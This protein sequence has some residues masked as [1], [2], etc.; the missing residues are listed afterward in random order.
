[1]ICC[2]ITEYTMSIICACHL[3]KI[4]ALCVKYTNNTRV[5][6]SI[7]V[8]AI[9][10]HHFNTCIQSLCAC[11]I[12]PTSIKCHHFNDA[13]FLFLAAKSL[14]NGLQLSQNT[15]FVRQRFCFLTY[16]ACNIYC[17]CFSAD[18]YVHSNRP[19]FY[20]MPQW[21]IWNALLALK[22]IHFYHHILYP[23]FH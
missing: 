19:Q 5:V 17:V 20:I 7:H 18:E 22:G 23:H 11:H 3:Y 6:L 10:I 15:A 1:M 12:F 9:E 21:R 13:I 16:I 4:A 8:S 2:C 14:Y